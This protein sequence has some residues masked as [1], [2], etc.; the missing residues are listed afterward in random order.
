MS[1]RPMTPNERS[2][3]E[4]ILARSHRAFDYLAQLSGCSVEPVDS[5]GSLRFV[6]SDRPPTSRRHRFLDV[7]GVFMDAD[8]IPVLICPFEDESGQ[9]YEL[10]I[11]KMGGG[12]ITSNLDAERISV[13]PA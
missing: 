6:W 7:K 3:L 4:K 5:S 10:D 12:K 8:G 1:I 2:I 9:I 11:Q 13:E